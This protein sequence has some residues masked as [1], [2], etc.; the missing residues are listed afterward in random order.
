VTGADDDP[1][2]TVLDRLIEAVGRAARYVPGAE[3]PPAIVLWPDGDG[4]WRPL[5]SR[6][7][8]RLPQLLTLGPYDPEARTGPAIWIKCV[9]AGT[10]PAPKLPE[11]ETPIL[12][13]PSVARQTLRAG[14]E[15]PRSLQPLVELLYRGA[16]FLQK[17]GKDWTIEA[18]L[19]ASEGLG[20]DVAR[21]ARSREAMLGALEALG[22]TRVAALTGRRLD[23]EDFDRLLVE[24]PERDLLSWLSEP[25]ARRTGW[26]QARWSAFRARCRAE[27]GFDPES[28]GPLAGGERLGL[29]LSDRWKKAWRRFG[30]APLSFPGIPILLRRARP[31]G[32]L[33]LDFDPEPWPD[34][35]ERAEEELRDALAGLATLA[36]TEARARIR[37]LEATHGPRRAWV[38]T[39]LGESPLA[40]SLEALLR[41]AERTESALG[42]DGPEAMAALYRERGWGADDAALAALAE[43]A[44]AEDVQAVGALI[45]AVYLPWLEV[46]AERFQQEIERQ[47]LPA[48]GGLAVVEAREGESI[49]FVDGLRLDLGVRLV[50]VLE[51]NGFEVESR[52][53][54]AALPTVTANGKPAV[55]PLAG[56]LVGGQGAENFRPSLAGAALTTA[57]LRSTLEQRG[58]QLLDDESGDE[59]ATPSARGWSEDGALDELGHTLSPERF[60]RA[61]ADELRRLAERVERLLEAG[62]KRV[63]IVTDHGWLLLPGGLPKAALPAGLAVEKGA[64][65]ARLAG[66]P[67]APLQ[68]F[69]WHW[70]SAESFATPAGARAFLAGTTYA[71]GGVSL[72]ECVLPDLRVRRRAGLA[73]EPP[74][75]A[76]VRWTGLR[77]RVRASDAP[78]GARIDLRRQAMLANSSVAAEPKSL[79]GE[80][81]GALIVADD[82]LVGESVLVVLLDTEGRVLA[83]TP[84]AIGR[85][86]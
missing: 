65:C 77:C 55:S 52:W 28:D 2:A 76:E 44:R 59:P 62:W 64:R 22:E 31:V 70:N 69:P 8:L 25:E 30:E 61:L 5:L 27:Y 23:A 4:E 6:L 7:R 57:R 63:R 13:L 11:G 79:D 84:T 34:E 85:E 10:L 74:A 3:E 24:D 42:G 72:Q 14:E 83:K 73:T 80:G 71:H 15:C 38:W 68:R 33:P 43:V 58:Y 26:D 36:P 53:R 29:H 75:I 17:N 51:A 56:D 20:L 12:Y 40:R 37:A 9:I 54:W 1:G 45:R 78:Q 19:V 39:R 47:P 35:N 50:A 81:R 32:Q 41:L 18:F 49:V 67:T 60:A 86:S 21:D 66:E 48:R 46:S 82:T 16:L